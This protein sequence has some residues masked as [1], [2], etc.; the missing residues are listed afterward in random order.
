[1]IMPGV[2]KPH[3]RPWFSERLL[4]GMQFVGG[5]KPLDGQHRC[6]FGLQRQDG[7]GFDSLAIDMDNATA[8]LGSVAAHMRAGQ[9]QLLP[10]ELHQQS[11]SLDG[12]LDGFAVHGQRNG[13]HW[14]PPSLCEFYPSLSARVS[15]QGRQGLPARGSKKNAI[16]LVC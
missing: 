13:R 5:C 3:C 2:Q 11:A 12:S 15:G 4:H 8:A 6:A 7:A 14:Q 9:P 16:S 10:Q 1:M